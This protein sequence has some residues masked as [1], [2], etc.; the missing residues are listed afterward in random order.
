MPGSAWTTPG[1]RPAK[2]RRPAR[3]HFVRAHD[4]MNEDVLADPHDITASAI[5]YGEILIG[6]AAGQRHG[7]DTPGPDGK[8]GDARR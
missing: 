1:L 2:M 6:N 5:L 7:I 3:G 4:A 8:R